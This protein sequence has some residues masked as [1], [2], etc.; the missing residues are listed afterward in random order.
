MA[1]HVTVNHGVVG[2]SPTRG[3]EGPENSKLSSRV[4]Y[5]LFWKPVHRRG[6]FENPDPSAYSS[7]A[8]ASRSILRCHAS[9]ASLS[10]R[11]PIVI[12]PIVSVFYF[13]NSISF[14]QKKLTFLH[15]SI[16]FC[17]IEIY[18]WT[19]CY[20]DLEYVW[21]SSKCI[22]LDEPSIGIGRVHRKQVYSF[23]NG[24]ITEQR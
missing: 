9:I 8:S 17:S 2:S 10:P 20:D 5:C 6:N 21:H 12:S 7:S 11:N 4:F 14:G 1:E 3:A 15:A 18:F 22:V 16:S 24:I 19:Q 13:L 23:G